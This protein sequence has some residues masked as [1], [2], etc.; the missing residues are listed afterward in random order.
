MSETIR[1]IQTGN[2]PDPAG[3]YSQA[4]VHGDMVFVS[5]QLPI[6]PETGEWMMPKKGTGSWENP[7]PRIG[8]DESHPLR[9]PL[10]IKQAFEIANKHAPDQ[11][12]IINQHGQ[13]EAEGWETMKALVAYLRDHGLRVDGVGWQAHVYLGWEKEPGNVRR[14]GEIIRWCHDNNLEFHITEFNVFLR[15]E[16]KGKFEQQAD[17]FEAITRTVLDNRTSGVVGINFWHMADSEPQK[18]LQGCL[19]DPKH[20]PKPAY[21]RIKQLLESYAGD[22]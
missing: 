1:K 12:L 5:G 15:G 4:V 13:L 2:A 9:P 16:D 22:P 10:Y 7:W 20:N 19:F 8:F 17:T 6:V 21:F 3:H 11:Q 14:L 18:K